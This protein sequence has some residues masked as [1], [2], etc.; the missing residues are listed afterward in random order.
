MSPIPRSDVFLTVTIMS[1]AFLIEV[2]LFILIGM[3]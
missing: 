1:T 2:T 3:F